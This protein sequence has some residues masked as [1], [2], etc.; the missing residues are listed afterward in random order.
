MPQKFVGPV[1]PKPSLLRIP[2][3]ARLTSRPSERPRG[4]ARVARRCRLAYAYGA[5]VP[6][7]NR[8][9]LIPEL[10]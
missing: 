5:G 7:R 1:A 9:D 6:N 8:I 4:I 10:V 2:R 3:L